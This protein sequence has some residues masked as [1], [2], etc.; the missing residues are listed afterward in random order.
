VESEKTFWRMDF[1]CF[2]LSCATADGEALALGL[3]EEDLF[4]ILMYLNKGVSSNVALASDQP[5][6]G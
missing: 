6:C 2:P 1:F 4:A 5:N 3:V